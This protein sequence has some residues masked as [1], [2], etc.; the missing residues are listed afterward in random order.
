MALVLF[1]DEEGEM[2]SFSSDEE[3]IEALGHVVD[4]VFRVYV[5]LSDNHRASS[6]HHF[7]PHQFLEALSGLL[8]GPSGP[9][10]SGETGFAGCRGKKPGR[11]TGSAKGEN[12]K[13]CEMEGQKFR[14]LIVNTANAFLEP[15][16]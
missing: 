13:T 14:Q 1:A 6:V 3:L 10:G 12:E 16:G 7:N 2:V 8:A 4:G 15:L 11:E 5:E 9:C